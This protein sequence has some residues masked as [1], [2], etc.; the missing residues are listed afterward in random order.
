MA[1]E[2]EA[3]ADRT[4]KVAEAVG[5]RESPTFHLNAH[6]ER[7]SRSWPADPTR[8]VSIHIGQDDA[9]L[10]QHLFMN[11]VKLS[12]IAERLRLTPEVVQAYLSSRRHIVIPGDWDVSTSL[13]SRILGSLPQSRDYT[14]HVE[15]RLE[16]GQKLVVDV[17]VESSGGRID[18]KLRRVG[19]A[20]RING[21][22]ACFA[23]VLEIL[24]QTATDWFDD[25]RSMVR[26]LG[27]EVAIQCDPTESRREVAHG[28]V[29]DLRPLRS[30]MLELLEQ[31]L[32]SGCDEMEAWS[33]RLMVKLGAEPVI[34][35]SEQPNVSNPRVVRG[36]AGQSV[37][38]KA[39]AIYSSNPAAVEE[40]SWSVFVTGRDLFHE[41]NR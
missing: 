10:A 6:P 41:R 40:E 4:M 17:K 30:P 33:E 26:G 12:A 11:G 7:K 29:L 24:D 15:V 32:K 5:S 27:I 2:R 37:Y 14:V 22:L 1:R 18:G 28:A 39:A 34:I 35:Y 13:K 19:R 21:S 25:I 23:P 38:E 9:L 31:L 3:P 36:T 8:E 16:T 20:S